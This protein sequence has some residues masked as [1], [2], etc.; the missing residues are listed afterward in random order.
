M[1]LDLKATKDCSQ[2]STKRYHS[3]KE[4]DVFPFHAMVMSTNAFRSL[5]RKNNPTRNGCDDA[6]AS[7]LERAPLARLNKIYVG[8]GLDREIGSYES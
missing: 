3:K 8:L 5:N 4:N 2:K 7:F 1:P 6:P